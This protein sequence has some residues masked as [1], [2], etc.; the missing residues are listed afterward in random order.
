MPMTG[1]PKPLHSPII[2]DIQMALLMVLVVQRRRDL[3][4]DNMSLSKAIG[5]DERYA[6]SCKYW[7]L[8]K[9]N[10]AFCQIL[11]A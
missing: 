3:K 2:G 8:C 1:G 5:K 4:K 7:S 11:T 6:G 10:P 9:P